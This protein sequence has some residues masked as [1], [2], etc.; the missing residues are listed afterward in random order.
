MFAEG[1]ATNDL[2]KVLPAE[3]V[4]AAVGGSKS[5]PPAP[6]VDVLA[7]HG[8]P[9]AVR[10]QATIAKMPNGIRFAAFCGMLRTLPVYTPNI[11]RESCYEA[12]TRHLSLCGPRALTCLRALPSD[13]G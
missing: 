2:E 11:D 1:V 3:W 9:P 7:A 5:P 10:P 8:V 13:P 6:S 12:L 4:A